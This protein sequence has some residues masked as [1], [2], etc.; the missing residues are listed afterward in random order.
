MDNLI[1]L[2][3]IQ[4]SVVSSWREVILHFCSALWD[5]T[6]STASRCGVLSTGQMW[7]C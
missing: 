2:G 4:S 7:T 3:C 6:W 1:I 5:L